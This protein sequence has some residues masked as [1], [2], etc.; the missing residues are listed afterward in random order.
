MLAAPGTPS[1]CRKASFRLSPRKTPRETLRKPVAP[2]PRSWPHGRRHRSPGRRPARG[3]RG[4]HGVSC[5]APVLYG[6]ATRSGPESKAA[7]PAAPARARP[8]FAGSALIRHEAPERSIAGIIVA[9]ASVIVMPLLANAKR[10]V[11][12]SVGPK[13]PA[14]Y[15]VAPESG[16]FHVQNV[17]QQAG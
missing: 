7:P 6:L 1:V 2:L 8:D 13:T 12:K 9:A 10:R 17:A 3:L 4:R 14:A 15:S 5:A 11:A 16:A